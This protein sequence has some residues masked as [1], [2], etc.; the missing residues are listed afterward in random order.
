[1]ALS[2]EEYDLVINRTK[3]YPHGCGYKWG[4]G[5]LTDRNVIG[6]HGEKID[7]VLK[8]HPEYATEYG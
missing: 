4:F 5:P 7:E 1:M 8:E 6:T 3:E 2:I